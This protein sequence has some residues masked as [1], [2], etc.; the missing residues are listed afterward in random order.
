MYLLVV[1]KIGTVYRSVSSKVQ[2]PSSTGNTY[3]DVI[4]RTCLR[5]NLFQYLKSPNTGNW[6]I[7]LFT[8]I[9]KGGRNINQCVEKEIIE[10]KLVIVKSWDIVIGIFICDCADMI[11]GWW[12]VK[13]R[14]ENETDLF[15]SS[16]WQNWF[17]SMV[18]F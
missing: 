11:V 8:L 2:L 7:N 5:K 15:S 16:E 10:V 3:H 18:K 9:D 14:K 17:C 13:K 1:N 12:V 4:Q 6:K